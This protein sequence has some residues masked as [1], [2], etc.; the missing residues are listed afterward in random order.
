MSIPCY[1]EEK[2]VVPMAK[3]IIDQFE[4]NLPEYDYYIQ[5]IDNC[6]TDN[7]QKLLRHLCETNEK[8]RAIFNAR[9]F[10]MTSGYYGIIQTTGACTVSIPCDFQ[11]PVSLIPEMIREWEKGAKIVCLVKKKS[12]ESKFMWKIRQLYYK[13]S[14]AVSDV[15]IL[16]NFTGSG[17]YDKSFLDLC[18]R[19]KDPVVSFFQIISTLGYDIVKLEYVHE[20]RK[21]GKTKNN[22]FSLFNIA[23]ARV[24]TSSNIAPRFA[25]MIGFL[26]AILS[27][28]IGIV[29]LIFKLLFWDLF[30]AGMVPVL[31]G[32][33]FLGAIQIFLIG[34]VGEYVVT[35]NQRVMNR[36]L[37]V[38]KE[39]LNFHDASK[40]TVKDDDNE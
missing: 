21:K 35:I 29:Y 4:Q 30:S 32:V 33:F 13:M 24:V 36:P 3:A 31:I 15:K 18:R 25:L 6:S 1:N 37:V 16:K 22:F 5:F 27:L 9:N 8:I 14:S 2:N 26:L 7:T 17:L 19:I 10:P 40:Q 39:R 12:H 34:L 20:S 23:I 11:V 38:E 28:I